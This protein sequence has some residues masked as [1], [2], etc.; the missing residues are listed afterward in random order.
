MQ[1]S[2][3]SHRQSVIQ[4]NVLCPHYPCSAVDSV[5][6][7]TQEPETHWITRLIHDQ[8]SCPCFRMTISVSCPVLCIR[9]CQSGSSSITFDHEGRLLLFWSLTLGL[10]FWGEQKGKK[11]ASCSTSR[12]SLHFTSEKMCFHQN[13]SCCRTIGFS[14]GF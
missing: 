8:S 14:P 9:G 13:V 4:V 2:S 1:Q 10:L 11:C 12:H 7:D 5:P 6:R 3:S